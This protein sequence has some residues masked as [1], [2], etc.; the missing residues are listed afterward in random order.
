[1][2]LVKLMSSH[3]FQLPSSPLT[4]IDPAMM[5]VGRLLSFQILKILGVQVGLV[6][7]RCCHRTICPAQWLMSMRCSDLSLK[8]RR[9]GIKCSDTH[10]VHGYLFRM[11]AFF[12]FDLFG[13][14]AYCRRGQQVFIL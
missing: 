12:S 5:R 14:R 8:L 7:G 2:T 13:L 4:N 11:E 9:N 3:I 10:G 6:N 1:M